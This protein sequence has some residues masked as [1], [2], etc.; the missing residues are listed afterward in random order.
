MTHTLTA[1]LRAGWPFSAFFLSVFALLLLLN[2]WT[3]TWGDDWYRSLPPEDA[4]RMLA[5]IGDEYRNWTGRAGVLLATFVMLARWPLALV[6]FNLLNALAF[7]LLLAALFRIAAGRWPGARRTDLLSLL[8]AWMG[9]WFFTESFGEAVLWKTGAIAYLW[10]MLGA[11]CFATPYLE[12]LLDQE[13]TTDSR[14]RIWLW[15]LGSFW[16]GMALE[17]V[18]AVLIIACAISLLYRGLRTLPRWYLANAA[19][20]L[21][22]AAVLFAAPGNAVR[23]AMQDDHLPMTQR[24]GSLLLTIWQHTTQ[25]APIAV[26][27]LLLLVLNLTTR[28]GAELKRSWLL[29]LT[30]LLLALAMVGSTGINFATRTAF[31]AEIL[32]IATALALAHPLWD[33][34]WQ[35]FWHLPLLGIL[36]P[37]LGADVLTTLEQ[38]HATQQQTARREELMRLY[39][40]QG[41]HRIVLPSLQIP[42]LPQITDDFAKGRYF[43]RDIHGDTHGNGWRNGTY[44]VVHG[45]EFAT[46][47]PQTHV[48]YL[49]EISNMTIISSGAD[50]LLL[51]RHESSGWGSQRVLY[52]LQAQAACQPQLTLHWLASDSGKLPLLARKEGRVSE[53]LS[54]SGNVAVIRHDGLPSGEH[55]AWRLP[56]PDYAGQA[57]LQNIQG[58]KL[59][60][61][62]AD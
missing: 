31:P 20:L 53:T 52:L 39:Q 44:A 36:I 61:T 35:A 7:C 37:V 10:V 56:V 17:N 38:N 40:Q 15:P 57:E 47:L 13:P 45:F 4:G 54:Y 23:F 16:L 22:G 3:P 49:P 50:Y 30:G 48:I 34:G 59:A 25:V 11:L 9:V 2:T 21:A 18:S 26:V 51:Q 12:L 1:R 32:W 43:L 14:W 62:L 33:R 19:A 29:A 24:L 28:Q 6:I 42:Y 55:C 8:L 27:L 41:V 58:T 46:R 60:V 5:Q